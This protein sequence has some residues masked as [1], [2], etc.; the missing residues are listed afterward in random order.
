MERQKP[1]H[2]LRMRR[3]I[4]DWKKKKLPIQSEPIIEPRKIWGFLP[5]LSENLPMTG[6]VRA[7]VMICAERNIPIS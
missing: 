1:K 3:A 7:R 5:C 2:M 4:N 6:L